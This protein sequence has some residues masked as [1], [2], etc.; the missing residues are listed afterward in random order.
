MAGRCVAMAG[1]L[2]QYLFPF[3][4]RCLMFI[5]FPIQHSMLD[6]RPA[7]NAFVQILCSAYNVDV[8]AAIIILTL[9]TSHGRRVFDVHFFSILLII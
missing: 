5:S 6:V 8:S 1:K 4:I 9:S 2:F 7:R 3:N